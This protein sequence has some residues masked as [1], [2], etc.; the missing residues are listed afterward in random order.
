MLASFLM[1]RRLPRSTLFPYTTL[2]RSRIDEA[3]QNDFSTGV[4]IRRS[5]V[6]KLIGRTRPLN[7]AITNRDGTVVDH[8]EIAQLG[9]APSPARTSQ[10]QQLAS[11]DDVQILMPFRFANSRASSYPASA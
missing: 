3:G 6:G 1:L 10:S 5:P 11:V 4:E 8:T 9:A 2:F 7:D